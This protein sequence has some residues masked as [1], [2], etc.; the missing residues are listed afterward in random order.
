LHDDPSQFQLNP[1]YAYLFRQAME[2]R[3]HHLEEV[4]GNLPIIHKL[5]HFCVT[6]ATFKKE[7]PK[8]FWTHDQGCHLR[9]RKNSIASTRANRRAMESGRS[10]FGRSWG[11]LGLSEQRRKT[12]CK[13]HAKTGFEGKFHL[14]AIITNYHASREN[15]AVKGYMRLGQDCHSKRLETLG[16]V[17]CRGTP[18]I[19]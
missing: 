6:S 11:G 2:R 18:P 13:L 17:R 10:K 4:S 19:P 14:F 9:F 3:R 7:G 15:V 12:R 5:G 8:A 1:I 16:R